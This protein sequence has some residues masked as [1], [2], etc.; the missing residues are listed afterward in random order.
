M[1]RN[2]GPAGLWV[3]TGTTKKKTTPGSGGGNMRA[4]CPVIAGLGSIHD[5][6]RVVDKRGGGKP[7][8]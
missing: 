1:R 5:Y 4:H 6:K 3:P 7:R 2:A 8:E